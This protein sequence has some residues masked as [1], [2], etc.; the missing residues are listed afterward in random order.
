M[1]TYRILTTLGFLL[2][3]WLSFAG[4]TDS[5]GTE[6]LD[7][8][9]VIDDAQVHDSELAEAGDAEPDA[10]TTA[11]VPGLPKT[12]AIDYARDD[13]GTPLS[14]EE[15]DHFTRQ[16]MG[17]LKKIK[18]FNYLL[19]TTYGVDASTGMRDYQSWYE[20]SFRREGDK[21]IFFHPEDP[22]HGGHNVHTPS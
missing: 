20:E 8:S 10:D 16:V 2:V 3:S 12:L 21:V 1:R 7:G 4:C 9:E 5:A 11:T 13:V 15:I 6:T 14:Q 17:F 22:T 19:D 18:Y